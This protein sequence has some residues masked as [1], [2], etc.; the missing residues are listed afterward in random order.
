MVATRL[1]SAAAALLALAVVGAGAALPQ[2]AAAQGSDKGKSD[3]DLLQG[4]WEVVEA[5]KGGEKLPEEIIK[6]IKL[7]FK[8]DKFTFAAGDESKEGTFKLDPTKKPRAIDVSIDDKTIKGIYAF[9]G[10]KLK[11]CAGDAGQERP[12]EFKSEGEINLVVLQRAPAKKDKCDDCAPRAEPGG[13]K[14]KGGKQT[15]EQRFQGNWSVVSAVKAGEEVPDEILKT[16]KLRI[17]GDQITLEILGETRKGTFKLDPSK[18]PKTLDAVYE[19]KT[20]KSIYQFEKGKIKVCASEQERPTEFKADAGSQNILIVFQREAGDK[21]D[22]DKEKGGKTSA[23]LKKFAGAWIAVSAEKAGEKIPDEFLKTFKVTFAGDK[24]TIELAGMTK[25]G[26]LKVDPSKKPAA[27]DLTMDDKTGHGIY[28]FE[29]DTLKICGAEPGQERPKDFKGGDQQFVVVLKRAKAEKE[30]DKDKDAPKKEGAGLQEEVRRLRAELERVR[31]ELRQAQQRIED[32]RR[33]EQ[34][35]RVNEERAAVRAQFER[36]RAEE[37]A[38]RAEAQQEKAVRA[39]R[40][41]QGGAQEVASGNN[42]KILGLAMHTYHDAYRKFP[43]AAIYSKD[44][45]PLLSWRVAIL[46]YLDQDLLYKQFK[47]DEAW[48]SPHNKKLLAK[49]PKVFAPVLGDTPQPHSTFYRVFT[50]T[51]T[52]FPGTQGLRIVAVRDGTANTIM[53]VEAGEA[54]P[55]TK[56][57]EL[58]FDPKGKL[59]K[60]GGLFARGFNVLMVDGSIRFIRRDFD[61]EILRGAITPSGGEAIDLDK[62]SP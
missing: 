49:M 61:P 26:I 21:Q 24:V 59:P 20:I 3:N 18:K 15:D 41:I 9:E 5:E 27:I 54:V 12:K 44:G 10:K 48:D 40:A 28:A 52:M 19:D 55:W 33:Q 29:G 31:E 37:Q 42:L 2:R 16:F 50:G 60:L 47:L 56:P 36:R 23:E 4:T 6:T 45:K 53:A 8:G 1:R 32:A 38:R 14:A 25:E 35:A 62:L 11:I 57:D 43:A 39:A 22:K 7:T 13:E 30:K 17:K 51:G 58:P 34:E 46:P